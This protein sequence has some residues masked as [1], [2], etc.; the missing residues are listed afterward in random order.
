MTSFVYFDKVKFEKY[1]F[2]K[3]A[4]FDSIT[5]MSPILYLY[6]MV[7]YRPCLTIFKNFPKILKFSWTTFIKLKFFKA[8]V[9]K[10]IHMSRILKIDCIGVFRTQSN[11]YNT[12]FLPK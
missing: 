4:I 1:S 9:K 6:D 7:I 11:I 5:H 3:G 2:Y 10:I 8:R 12:T